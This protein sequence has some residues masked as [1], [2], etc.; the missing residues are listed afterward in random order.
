MAIGG[1]KNYIGGTVFREISLNGDVLQLKDAYESLYKAYICPV[2]KVLTLVILLFCPYGN[3]RF[4]F[5]DRQHNEIDG[6]SV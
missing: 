5:P 4:P 6:S 3:F 2:P 1:K